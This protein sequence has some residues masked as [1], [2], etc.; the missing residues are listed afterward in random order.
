MD[1]MNDLTDYK[2]TELESCGSTNDVIKR[3]ISDNLKQFPL[4][5]SSREQLKGRGRGNRG[6]FS[7]RGTGLYVS[8]GLLLESRETV[9]LLSLVSGLAV[10]KTLENLSHHNFRLKWPNDVLFQKK[11]I[12]GVL[13][14]NSFNGDKMVSVTGI[15]INL[16]MGQD[17]FPEGLREKATSLRIITGRSVNIK[18]VTPVLVDI[19]FKEIARLERGDTPGIVQSANRLS[20]YS[21]GDP[22]SVHLDEKKFFG[23][24]R[25]I[26]HDGGLIL[27][28]ANGQR[29]T[30]YSGEIGF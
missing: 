29:D 26:N 5:V 28:K 21:S 3:S 2:I 12:A 6:W 16:N 10:I 24:Y 22:V 4:I 30:I 20:A 19:F 8:I 17:D 27:E 7:P 11:K 15:G 18:R 23:I 14:E 13:T 9:Q 25:G 1:T